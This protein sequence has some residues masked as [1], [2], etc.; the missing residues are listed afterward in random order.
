MRLVPKAP[1]AT[2]S[3]RLLIASLGPALL[4]C[5]PSDRASAAFGPAGGAVISTPPLKPI[6]INEHTIVDMRRV[7]RVGADAF[8]MKDIVR[9]VRGDS[10]KTEKLKEI[11]TDAS[12]DNAEKLKRAST[13][14]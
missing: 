7:V 4:T 14:V 13:L 9:M 11:L 2:L 10:E 5:R 6:V 3:R 12:I 8:S 1:S